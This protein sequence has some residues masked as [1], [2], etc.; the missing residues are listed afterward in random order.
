MSRRLAGRI[1][2]KVASL[3]RSTDA[4]QAVYGAA[5]RQARRAVD[6][7]QAKTTLGHEVY[8][9]GD[10]VRKAL[11]LLRRDRTEFVS[12][13]AYR[14]LDAVAREAPVD[15][16][17]ADELVIFEREEEL[18]RASVAAAFAQLAE[19]EPRLNEVAQCSRVATLESS[20]HA[21]E[22]LAARRR[23]GAL[24]RDLIGPLAQHDDPLIRS[25]L[26]LSVVSHYLAIVMGEL[27]AECRTE[28]YFSTRRKVMARSG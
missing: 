20:S 13:R 19:M 10:G 23:Q 8:T 15:A 16:I 6:D 4:A 14:L 7:E 3:D 21:S 18:G 25:Q 5:T 17:A 12:D 11:E 28:S 24:L 27:P 2:A 26:A 1:M 22:L 9:H